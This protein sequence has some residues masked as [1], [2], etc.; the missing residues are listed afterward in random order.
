MQ[1]VFKQYFPVLSSLIYN[2]NNFAININLIKC[3]T[4]M[5]GEYRGSNVVAYKL[6]EPLAYFTE[7]L[8]TLCCCCKILFHRQ[9]SWE[10]F[11]F[12]GRSVFCSTISV[13]HQFTT[14][15]CVA[16]LLV[17]SNWKYLSCFVLYSCLKLTTKHDNTFIYEFIFFHLRS[18]Q[19]HFNTSIIK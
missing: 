14:M 10:W 7:H 1:C 18:F 4:C 16:L 9:S 8:R 15:C 6:V 19:V 2:H 3:S 5:I 11:M 17:N 13:S 12:R